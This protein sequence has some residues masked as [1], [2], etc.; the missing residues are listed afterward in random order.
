MPACKRCGLICSS[1]YNLNLH[2]NKEIPCTSDIKCQR[3]NQVFA[4][5][6]NLNS[7]MNKKFPCVAVNQPSSSNSIAELELKLAIEKEKTH[8]MERIEKEKTER[9]KEKTKRKMMTPQIINMAVEVKIDTAN[10]EELNQYVSTSLSFDT[11]IVQYYKDYYLDNFNHSDISAIIRRCHTI[12]SIIIEILKLFFNISGDHYKCQR[13]VFYKEN[14]KKFYI[15]K[16][17][18]V[19]RADFKTDIYP[20]IREILLPML[21][22]IRN[23]YKIPPTIS[24]ESDEYMSAHMLA[25]QLAD[26]KSYL[27]KYMI[28]DEEIIGQAFN[29]NNIIDYSL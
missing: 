25:G 4:N 2:L 26:P 14:N 9:E 28:E 17:N 10:I 13:C 22:K 27:D 18:Q 12:N 5:K 29:T 20:I 23:I 21:C 15:I 8:R 6:R 24:Y 3:C 19:K 1:D 16:D 11:D 7:H